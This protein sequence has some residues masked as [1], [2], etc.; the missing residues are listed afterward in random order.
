LYKLKR[1]DLKAFAV[2]H[3]IEGAAGTKGIDT[4]KSAL[5]KS[6]NKKKLIGLSVTYDAIDSKCSL[7][8]A[9]EHS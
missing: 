2:C 1:R 7:N 3:A 9:R 6:E 8:S 5:A 4:L